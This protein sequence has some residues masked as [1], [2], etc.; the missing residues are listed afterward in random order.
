MIKV[1]WLAAGVLEIPSSVGLV[2]GQLRWR[3]NCTLV[4]H[5]NKR[6]TERTNKK[7]IIMTKDTQILYSSEIGFAFTGRNIKKKFLELKHLK[8]LKTCRDRSLGLDL[9]CTG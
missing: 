5:G 4:L 6:P 9:Y 2:N 8:N 1:Q 3:R 7:E